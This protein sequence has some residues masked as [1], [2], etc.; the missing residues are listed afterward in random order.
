MA[1]DCKCEIF[2]GRGVMALNLCFKNTI[3]PPAVH[4]VDEEVCVRTVLK[5]AAPN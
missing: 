3:L 2:S 4:S 5:Y 1:S